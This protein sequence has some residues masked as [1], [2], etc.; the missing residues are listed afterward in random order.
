MLLSIQVIVPTIEDINACLTV[1]D[2]LALPMDN[3]ASIIN[4]E[5]LRSF[6]PAPFL[7]SAILAAGS[8]SP[9]ALILMGRAAREELIN[10][11]NEDED[12]DEEDVTA[13]VK[14]FSLWCLGVLQGKVAESRFSIAPDDSKLNDWC[15]CLHCAHIMPIIKATASFCASTTDTANIIRSLTA[16][17]SRTSKEAEHQNKIHRKQLDYIKEKN[18]R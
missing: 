3:A 6:F 11:H 14:L 17:I 12:F 13:H 4:L 7:P 15:A 2:L 1:N 18:A 10:T 16:G 9:L 8:L 5:A